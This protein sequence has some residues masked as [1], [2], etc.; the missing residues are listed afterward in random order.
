MGFRRKINFGSLTNTAIR[1]EKV[2]SP[3]TALQR[4]PIATRVWCA[5]G[6]Y[7]Y[8]FVRNLLLSLSVKSFGNRLAF[9]K[10]K[11]QKWSGTYFFSGHDVV[12]EHTHHQHLGPNSFGEQEPIDF[13]YQS[14]LCLSCWSCV[15]LT[16]C[17]S[18]WQAVLVSVAR[19][20][21]LNAHK[22]S[23]GMMRSLQQPQVQEFTFSGQSCHRAAAIFY[24]VKTR[25]RISYL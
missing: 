6:Y 12:S 8:R 24:T 16:R 20:C 15:Q 4:T 22:L 10:V 21:K 17:W 13:D 3:F 9:R 11:R 19:L 25:G 1:V 2:A 23:Q 7:N 14:S 18:E 5:V